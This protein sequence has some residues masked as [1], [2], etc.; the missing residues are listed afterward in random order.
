[1]AAA[2]AALIAPLSAWRLS[3]D[4]AVT[5]PYLVR[6]YIAETDEHTLIALAG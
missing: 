4:R 1:M 3:V 6:K 2:V 5:E